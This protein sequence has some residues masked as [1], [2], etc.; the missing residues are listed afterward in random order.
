MKVFL[1]L[2][3][4]LT[5]QWAYG[6]E[7]AKDKA[8]KIGL[9]AIEK[10]F[11]SYKKSEPFVVQDRGSKWLVFGTLPKGSIGG[12]PEA[13]IDKTNCKVIDVYHTQ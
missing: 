12:T 13:L 8:L 10:M 6:Q 4:L 3:F 9:I 11:S 7:C 2:A 5:V 1:A